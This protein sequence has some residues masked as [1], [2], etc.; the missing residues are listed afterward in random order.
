MTCPC[1]LTLLLSAVVSQRCPA[2]LVSFDCNPP[3][4]DELSWFSPYRC[5]MVWGKHPLA[6]TRPVIVGF[7]V[8]GRSKAPRFWCREAR[9]R[10]AFEHRAAEGYAM[11]AM[12]EDAIPPL[13]YLAGCVA[14]IS[15]KVRG[16]THGDCPAA[17]HKRTQVSSDTHAHALH[18]GKLAV[19]SA[20]LAQQG[21]KTGEDGTGVLGFW[22][23]VLA[24]CQNAE[25]QS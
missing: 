13:S 3:T 20:L 21:R 12:A 10:T 1:L 9:N 4:V 7:K 17:M 23:V 16:D 24:I 14:C 5:S 25:W 19:L 11:L 18:M 2:G 6:C 15:D 22:L 8:P